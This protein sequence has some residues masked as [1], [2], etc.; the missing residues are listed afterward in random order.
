[1]EDSLFNRP[2]ASAP[3]RLNDDAV[4]YALLMRGVGQEIKNDTSA[5]KQRILRRL[6]PKTKGLRDFVKN[7]EDS[8]EQLVVRGA[9]D[10]VNILEV[11]YNIVHSKFHIENLPA[12]DNT[13]MET[14]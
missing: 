6:A 3:P 4:M 14:D 13:T 8:D 5:G 2:D 7:L 10:A 1:M 9:E 11:V 12:P